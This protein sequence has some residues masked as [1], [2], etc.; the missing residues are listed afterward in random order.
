MANIATG[1]KYITTLLLLLA[2]FGVYAWVTD[3]PPTANGHTLSSGLA[4]EGYT[5]ATGVYCNSCH[6]GN[7]L[8]TEGGSVTVAGLPTGN[9]EAGKTYNF[10]LTIIHGQADRRRWGF[11][12]IAV[13]KAGSK[14]GTFASTNPNALINGDEL[15]QANAP[16]TSSRTSY[17][18]DQLSWKAPTNPTAD[19]ATIT[20][21]YVANAANA[22]GGTLG[23]YIY[24]SSHKVD[25]QLIYTFTGN[26]LWSNPANWAGQNPPPAIIQ[27]SGEIK[28]NPSPGGQ[29]LLTQPQTMGAGTR[30]TLAP[31]AQ[32]VLQ[33]G[34]LIQQ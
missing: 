30:L 32:L 19:D 15:S 33:G 10:S 28:I 13:D 2:S 34:L 12:I 4:P 9:Y 11:S 21:F 25:L 18:F 16:T 31:N 27:G 22:A 23:D 6:Q 20:F 7:N 26:G 29:C 5:G 24:A 17:T 14:T 1:T 3:Q 8:N